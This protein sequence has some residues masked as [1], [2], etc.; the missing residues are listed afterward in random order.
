MFTAF[1]GIVAVLLVLRFLVALSF[2][3]FSLAAI[4]ICL[5]AVVGYSCYYR[6]VQ[7]D[8]PP[9]P[10]QVAAIE[11]RKVEI[12]EA[13]IPKLFSQTSDGCAVYKFVDNG[14]NH[15]F[16]RCERQVSTD[17]TYR[18]GKSTKVETIQTNQEQAK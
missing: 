12:E 15:Y 3:E 13:K 7:P 8:P 18:S 1:L 14:Y 2:G 9:T 11:K 4:F 17:S 16:T 5:A 6:V 10:E